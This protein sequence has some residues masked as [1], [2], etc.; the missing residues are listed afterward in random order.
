MLRDQVEEKYP[1][2]SWRLVSCLL[3]WRE[4]DHYTHRS[5]AVHQ[6]HHF[7]CQAWSG[8]IKT[9]SVKCKQVTNGRHVYL[10]VLLWLLHPCMLN[11]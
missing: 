5:E 7:Q 11:E 8:R 2:W 6:C 9:K 3:G 4:R 10:H 1:S